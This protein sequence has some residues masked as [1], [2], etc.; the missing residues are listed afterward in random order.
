L[1]LLVVSPVAPTR[2]G[3]G[4]ELFFDL[5]LVVGAYSAAS[6][7]RHRWPFLALTVLTL[8]VRWADVARGVDGFSPI[9]IGFVVVWLAYAVS[10]V[11]AHL[12][13]MERV[14]TNAILGA[15]VAYV[16]AAVAFSSCFELLERLQPHSFAGLPEGGTH[17]D[18]GVA[19]LYF[20]IVS[21][22]TM[23][24][25]DILPVSALARSLASL[26]GIFGTLYLAV[27]IARMVGLHRHDVDE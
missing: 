27:M 24:Y 10:L 8:G 3:Y 1:V 15:I 12:F 19:L 17:H 16:L 11:V 20:S 9:A 18:T 26:E 21:I 6:Q 5:V 13:R 7:G 25:G 2:A 23:G 14:N 22:T 4:V